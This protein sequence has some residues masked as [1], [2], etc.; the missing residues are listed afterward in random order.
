MEAYS[1]AALAYVLNNQHDEAQN[2]LSEIEKDVIGINENQKCFKLL[3]KDTK[4]DLRHTSFAA[5]T[6][7]TMNR[8]DE[9]KALIPYIY[10]EYKNKSFS[11]NPDYGIPIEALARFLIA[12]PDYLPT[13]LTVTLTNE[14]DFKKVVHITAENQRESVEVIYP[15][16]TL[17]P[18]I[19]IQGIGYVSIENIVEKIFELNGYINSQF[20][21]KV[22]IPAST[23]I[24]RIIQVCATYEPPDDDYHMKTLS[25][26]IYDVEIPP[27]YIYKET[28]DMASKPEIKVCMDNF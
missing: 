17:D 24:I 15:D 10:N 21:L 26:V 28:V 25:N 22:K 11:K 8:F 1:V 27:G 6:Y 23:S 4:C 3:T 20:I 12:R 5:I 7:L 14:F 9:A 18:K 19:T 16:Y 13:N 2:M